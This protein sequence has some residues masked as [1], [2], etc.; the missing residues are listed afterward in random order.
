MT[1]K[2]KTILIIS[3]G[4]AEDAIACS[5]IH[6][7]KHEK[8][9]FIGAPLVGHGFHY[10]K[11]NIPLCCPTKNMPSCGFANQS[12][13]TLLKDIKAGL[14]TLLLKQIRSI[15][16][17]KKHID[18]V[19]SCGDV[20]PQIIAR[21]TSKPHISI[22]TALSE[23]YI[24]NDKKHLKPFVHTLEQK[25][26]WSDCVF[27]PFDRLL[28]RSSYCQGVFVRDA[29]TN[30][31]LKKFN[32]ASYYLGN[33]M[34][35]N[36]DETKN[37][38]ELNPNLSTLLLLPGSRGPEIYKNLKQMVEVL[39]Y[40]PNT[41]NITLALATSLDHDLCQHICDTLPMPVHIYHN[42]FPALLNGADAVF[43]MSGTAAEQAI[44]KGL[45]VISIPGHGPQFT[46]KFAHAQNRLLGDGYTLLENKDKNQTANFIDKV[47][48]SSKPLYY[49]ANAHKRMGQPG[50]SM[51]IAKKIDNLFK[52]NI[53]E[54]G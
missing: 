52:L 4:P 40:L 49:K 13:K 36:L 22:F 2:I 44:G 25:G 8:I 27:S 1:N 16:R 37:F 14:P 42:M 11:N 29:L 38:P 33:P 35:D 20:L 19:I 10:V 54:A 51:A 45:P 43:S 15:I 28:M 46:F 6:Y 41:F 12:F 39:K 3:N 7:L 47:L 30:E 50:A 17:Q 53:H 34:M 48:S 18:Y 32:I 23:Y 21:L 26:L 5:I 24:R 31:K 9:K